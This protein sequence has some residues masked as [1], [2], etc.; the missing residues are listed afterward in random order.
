MSSVRFDRSLQ[1][2]ARAEPVCP[3]GGTASGAAWFGVF[4]APL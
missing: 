1:T 4:D 2:Y 3:D